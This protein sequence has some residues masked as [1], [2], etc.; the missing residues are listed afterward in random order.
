MGKVIVIPVIILAIAFAAFMYCRASNILK[1][2]DKMLDSAVN[3]SF[4][5]DDFTEAQLSK[6]ESKMYR[7]LTAGKI[8][9][10]KISEE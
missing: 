9:R 6:L 7:Y 2:I 4:S 8:A 1:R 3:N 10:N 5:E